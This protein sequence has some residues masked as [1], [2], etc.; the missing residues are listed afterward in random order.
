[1]RLFRQHTKLN[2][3][4]G[5]ALLFALITAFVLSFIGGSLVLLT[6]NQYRIVTGEIERIKAFYRA[7]AGAEYAIYWAY[8]NPGSLPSA[9]GSTV[10]VTGHSLPNTT[11][12]IT[13]INPAS[14]DPFKNISD[15]GI[16]VSTT[17]SG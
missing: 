5:G 16:K 6:T 9:P 13:S 12:T 3:A 10:P 2:N 1:M 17:Y 7:Q 15:Y 4:S 11:V 8:T 14:P